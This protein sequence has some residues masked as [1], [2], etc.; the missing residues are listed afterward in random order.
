MLHTCQY[1]QG[2]VQQESRG[3]IFD[4]DWSVLLHP[5]YLPDQVIFISFLFSLQ[6]APNDKNPKRSEENVYQKRSTKPA[7]IYLRGIRKLPDKL[8]EM[9][10][11]KGEYTV[12]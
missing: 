9:I 5:P 10:Q 11:N 2:H 1:M 8:E 12:D 6:N 4:L 3:Q 7:E